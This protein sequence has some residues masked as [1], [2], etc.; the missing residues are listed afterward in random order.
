MSIELTLL[1]NRFYIDLPRAPIEWIGWLAFLI[2]TLVWLWNEKQGSARRAELKSAPPA[3]PV[4]VWWAITLGLIPFTGLFLILRLP[5]TNVLPLPGTPVDPS[6]PALVFFAL[7]PLTL[8]AGFLGVAPA[9]FVGLLSGLVH[10]FWETHSLFTPLEFA[11]LGTALSIAFQQPYRTLTFRLLR[12][13][14]L[15]AGVLAILYPVLSIYI[16]TFISSGTLA[17][18]LDYALTNLASA[19]PAMAGELLI[20]GVFAQGL[21]WMFHASWGSREPSQPSPIERHL[22]IRFLYSIAPLAII[23]AITLVVSIWVIAGAA[24]RDMLHKQMESAANVAA[25]SIPYFLETGQNLIQQV[26]VDPRWLTDGF[27]D[28]NAALEQQLRLI[29]FLSSFSFWIPNRR[30]SPVTPWMITAVQRPPPKR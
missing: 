17:N 28:Q 9:F 5:A 10:A 19:W 18:R 2:L 21:A 25:E 22:H 14:L 7:L 23:L 24:A 3:Q 11:L 20:A 26:A 6:G 12:S 1:E 8:A 29:P 4:R 27:A 16:D 13:S 15:T 30:R